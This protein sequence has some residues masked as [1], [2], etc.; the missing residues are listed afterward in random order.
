MTNET[1]SL[2]RRVEQVAVRRIV[3]VPEGLKK[4][5]AK[6]YTPNYQPPPKHLD[7]KS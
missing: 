7:Y 3:R 6:A 2:V 5:A 1:N 4:L